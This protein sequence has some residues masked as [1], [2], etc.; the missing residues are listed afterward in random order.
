MS[1]APIAYAAAWF[2]G[3]MLASIIQVVAILIIAVLGLSMLWGHVS[4]RRGGLAILGCFVMFGSGGIAAALIGG[5][6][7]ETTVA[8]A[9]LDPLVASPTPRAN[10]SN[11]AQADPYA[12]ASLA[13]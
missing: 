12:G 7:T 6:R 3:G 8:P 10:T 2:S 11:P 1:E 13:Q 9:P 5:S 4:V